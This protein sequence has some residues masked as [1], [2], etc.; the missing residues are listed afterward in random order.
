MEDKWFSGTTEMEKYM[1]T[2]RWKKG[3]F[4]ILKSWLKVEDTGGAKYM[5]GD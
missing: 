5:S 2:W 3:Q 4:L 1:W